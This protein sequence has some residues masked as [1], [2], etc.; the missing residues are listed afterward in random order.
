ASCLALRWDEGVGFLERARERI[1]TTGAGGEWG[2]KIDGVEA[3]C[4]AGMGERERSLTLARKGVEQ[5]RAASLDLMR[6]H[7]G[8]MRARVLRMVGGVQHQGELEAQ[9]AETLEL[10]ACSGY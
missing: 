10:I 2:I 4:W 1:A 8:M 3:L 5:A 6:C 9:I 7:Q